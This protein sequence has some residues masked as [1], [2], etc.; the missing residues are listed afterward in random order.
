M[1]ILLGIAM[2]SFV[3]IH[4]AQASHVAPGP[5]V[6]CYDFSDMVTGTQFFPGDVISTTDLT[7][8][9]RP[10][11]TLAGVPINNAAQHADISQ[12][13][14]A[15]VAPDEFHGYFVNTRMIPTV[16]QTSVS[17][18]FA[19]NTGENNA[20]LYSNLAINGEFVQLANGLASANGLVLGNNTQGQVLVTTTLT[21]PAPGSPAQWING[22]VEF[23]ALTGS[24][25]AFTIGSPQYKF[26]D[27]CLTQ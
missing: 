17:M 23:T 21:N 7:T 13:S 18:H 20:F 5:G 12:S 14:T 8:E 11:R 22:T 26:D 1:E 2:L 6:V 19:Q 4:S 9:I 16:P 27:V 24:I 3:A 15:G 10:L 25:N